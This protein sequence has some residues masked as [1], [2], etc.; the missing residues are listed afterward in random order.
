[1]TGKP[2]ICPS[3]GDGAGGCEG[4][5]AGALGA[6]AGGSGTGAL[7][8]GGGVSG[9][10]ALGAGEE[11]SGAGALGAEE[12]ASG[13]GVASTVTV[14]MVI[15]VSVTMVTPLA[16]EEGAGAADEGA[17]GAAG[18]EGAAI[19]DVAGADVIGTVSDGAA[20]G[21]GTSVAF[22]LTEADQAVYSAPVGA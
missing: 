7:W 18:A 16:T 21:S 9:A 6:G 3:T 12:G 17:G 4:A 1:M 11:A 5:G 10:G 22:A 8:V 13:A 15:T 20:F 14:L 2:F 19:G